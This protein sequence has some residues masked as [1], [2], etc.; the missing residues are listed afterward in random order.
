MALLESNGAAWIK[1]VAAWQ[2]GVARGHRGIACAVSYGSSSRSL[3]LIIEPPTV[4]PRDE[5]VA[6]FHRRLPRLAAAPSIA[7]AAAAA[8]LVHPQVAAAATG[9]PFLPRRQQAICLSWSWIGQ[10]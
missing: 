7:R 8:A 6:F 5:T 9:R 1:V 4:K 2:R 3:I 10:L